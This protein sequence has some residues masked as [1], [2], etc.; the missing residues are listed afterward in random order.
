MLK[1]KSTWTPQ[2]DETERDGHLFVSFIH[3]SHCMK[4]IPM[5]FFIIPIS[6]FDQFKQ[7]IDIFHLNCASVSRILV[8]SN[9]I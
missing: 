2:T 5:Y 6:E 4:T 3:S 9:L 8:Y 1:E 7:P